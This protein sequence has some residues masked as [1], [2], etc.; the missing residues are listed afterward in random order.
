ML[1]R[2]AVLTSKQ[3]VI[4]ITDI[5][6]IEQMNSVANKL[7]IYRQGSAF[8]SCLYQSNLSAF[9]SES[10]KLWLALLTTESLVSRH[11]NIQ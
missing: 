8:A 6:R 3:L 4:V 10:G 2:I 1:S 7:Q 11:R 5:A 9:A